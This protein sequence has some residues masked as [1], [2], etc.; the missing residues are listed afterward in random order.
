MSF[1]FNE[2]SMDFESVIENDTKARKLA[3]EALC[4]L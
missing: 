4:N 1:D 3:K 2:T